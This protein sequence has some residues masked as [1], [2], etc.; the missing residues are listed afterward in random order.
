MWL[1]SNDACS[2]YFT[3][4]QN[5]RMETCIICSEQVRSCQLSVTDEG[6]SVPGIA[7]GIVLE[8]EPSGKKQE[9]E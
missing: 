4:A 1:R 7:H 9:V 2:I 6:E 3:K 8:H 5:R